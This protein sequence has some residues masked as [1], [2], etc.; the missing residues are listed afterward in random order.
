MY[1]LVENLILYIPR[2]MMKMSFFPLININ[3]PLQFSMHSTFYSKNISSHSVR[4]GDIHPTFPMS[5]T[6]YTIRSMGG[7]SHLINSGLGRPVY[8]GQD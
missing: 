1:R 4:D 7:D 8:D 3:R 6:H 2:L 5:T